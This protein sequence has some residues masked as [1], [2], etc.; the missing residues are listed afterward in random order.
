MTE[1]KKR[2]APWTPAENTAICRLYGAMLDHVAK[3]NKYSKA[4]MI[5]Q[6][7]GEN[8]PTAEL[9]ALAPLSTRSKGSIE[10]KLMNLTAVLQDLGI[11]HTMAEHGYVPLP[12][13]QAT[14]KEAAAYHWKNQIAAIHEDTNAA[15]FARMGR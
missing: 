1:A 3:G 10:A 4:A 13:Y 15:S 2:P 7:R 11:K 9:R 6:Y 8:D 12:N 14:L 5:R